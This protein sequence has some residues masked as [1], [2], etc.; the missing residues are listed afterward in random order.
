MNK[1]SLLLIGAGGHA[2]SCI[3]VIEQQGHYQI[4]GLVGLPDEVDTSHLGYS[5]IGS[6]RDLYKLSK[7]YEFALITIGQIKTAEPRMNLFCSASE[8]G[9]KFPI[10][11]FF[12]K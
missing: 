1:P 11:I 8:L 4:A 9:F 5:I 6:D 3:D 12:I 7:I 2:R 10:I